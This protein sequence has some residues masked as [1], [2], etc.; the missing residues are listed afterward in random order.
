MCDIQIEN[1][2]GY[3]I[4]GSVYKG[5]Y[6]KE[7]NNKVA[8]KQITKNN[9]K[10]VQTEKNILQILKENYND[11]FLK[12]I[13]FL[14]DDNYYYIITELLD[15][16]INLRRYINIYIYKYE[17][18]NN[19]PKIYYNLING[20][21][22]MHELKIVHR[23]IKPENIMINPY[24]NNIKYI[25]FGLSLHDDNYNKLLVVGTKSYLSPEIYNH[26]KNIP[27]LYNEW[28]NNDIWSLGMV[29]LY[30]I[31][32]ENYYK[33]SYKK[34]GYNKRYF[35]DGYSDYSEYS[36][37]TLVDYHNELLESRT[38]VDFKIIPT[39]FKNK[40]PF[41]FNGCID[42]LNIDTTKRKIPDIS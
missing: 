17:D 29:I 21:N 28:L 13:D 38:P 39:K 41:I 18:D 32:K 4:Y 6:K 25:D 1:K 33:Y 5:C 31:L 30:L 2:I 8:I 16:Y 22:K 19:I 9:K 24:N 12:Y 15:D 40:Y 10:F 37:F 36:D 35:K 7:P 14:Y 34:K 20:L 11:N 27:I 23:D 42:M 26:E 3:G